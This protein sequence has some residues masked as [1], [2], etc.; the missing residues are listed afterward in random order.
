MGEVAL[1]H[2]VVGFYNVINITSVNTD[3]DTHD[4]VLWPF[5]NT[6]VDAKEIRTL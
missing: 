6:V 1:R 4:H 5:G 2:E 3:G